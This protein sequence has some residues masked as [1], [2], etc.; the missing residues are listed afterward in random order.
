MDIRKI[1]DNPDTLAKCDRLVSD[2]IRDPDRAQEVAQ[3]VFLCMLEYDEAIEIDWT[4]EK[5]IEV[6]QSQI[7]A[8]NCRI[9]RQTDPTFDREVKLD[10]TPDPEQNHVD[11]INLD[12]LSRLP[13]N[14]VETARLLSTGHTAS[15]TATIQQIDPRHV[16]RRRIA[17]QEILL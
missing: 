3:E 6:F 7:N 1:L 12:I 4:E 14:L 16:R 15:Q 2:R 5:V 13:D 17:I 8:V 10:N 9:K 11:L